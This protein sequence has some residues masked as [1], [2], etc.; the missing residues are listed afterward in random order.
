MFIRSQDIW[1]G[2]L[3]KIDAYEFKILSCLNGV[4]TRGWSKIPLYQ[5]I[6]RDYYDEGYLASCISVKRLTELTGLSVS[7]I[8]RCSKSLEKKGFIKKFRVLT[9]VNQGSITKSWKN[10]YVIGE[11]KMDNG[12][13]HEELYFTNKKLREESVRQTEVPENNEDD[14]SVV[15]TDEEKVDPED[16]KKL[17]K[18]LR[19]VFRE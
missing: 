1:D 12:K 7:T 19:D 5:E 17:M 3:T 6:K 15:Q 2:L 10:V 14:Q 8:N 4:A 18:Q 13:K 11:W 9:N 16:H